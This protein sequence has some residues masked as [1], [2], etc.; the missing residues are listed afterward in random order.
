[1]LHMGIASWP[2]CPGSARSSSSSGVLLAFEASAFRTAGRSNSI[3][4]TSAASVCAGKEAPAA[5]AAAAVAAAAPLMHLP[6][7]PASNG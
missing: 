4:G 1:M 7:M 5:M 6:S 2:D 3:T